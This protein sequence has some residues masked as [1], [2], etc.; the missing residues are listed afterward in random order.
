MLR[1][2]R[3]FSRFCLL[4]SFL[5]SLGS[6]F[7]SNLVAMGRRDGSSSYSSSNMGQQAPETWIRETFSV[8]KLWSQEGRE[9]IHVFFF[10]FFFCNQRVITLQYCDGFAIYQH[11]SAIGIHMPPPSWTPPTPSHPARLSQSTGFGCPAS[12]S[13]L[14]LAIYFT[15]GNVYVLMLFS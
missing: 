11:E 15:R 5:C 12:Y 9:I 7:P 8:E 1:E 3:K 14:P 10:F 2:W 13:R 4:V 6:Q